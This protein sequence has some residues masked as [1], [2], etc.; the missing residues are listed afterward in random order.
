MLLK[1]LVL[2]TFLFLLFSFL[3]SLNINIRK[4]GKKEGRRGL[5][6]QKKNRSKDVTLIYL[7]MVLPPSRLQ[8]SA[9]QIAQT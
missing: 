5:E 6:S 3:K 7:C 9:S 1:V 4:E 2:F 8:L